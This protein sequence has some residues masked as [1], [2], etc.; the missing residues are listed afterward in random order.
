MIY[1]GTCGYAYKDWLGPFY[2]ATARQSEMLPFYAGCF[3]AVEID[4]SYYGI[5]QPATVARMN[6]NT[7]P[8]FRFCF[9]APQTVTH[10]PDASVTRIHDD[11]PAFVESVMPIV[12]AGKFGCALI[13]FPNGFKPTQTAEAYLQRAV[14]ALRPLRL[15][16]EFRNRE[17]QTPR[18]HEMLSELDVGWCNVDMPRYDSLLVPSSD[19][20]SGTGY[21]RFHG[22]NAAQWW[23]GDNTTRYDY[24]YN[25][26]ELVPWADRV[27]EIDDRVEATYAFFNNHA[28][29][30]AARNAEMFIDLLRERYGDAADQYV[31]NRKPRPAQGSLFE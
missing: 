31:S 23:T 6:A 24:N 28:R 14:E 30:N 5:L 1:V 22:R 9:K 11:A 15:V 29:G 2:P 4:S 26:E 25:T 8:A 10:P 18:T 19:V 12:Q 13:Q 17:W 16:A 7:P 20:T 21:V 27:A 3:Q